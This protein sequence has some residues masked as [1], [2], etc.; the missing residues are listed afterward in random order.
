MCVCVHTQPL[1]LIVHRFLCVHSIILY[2]IFV[3]KTGFFHIV[4][5]CM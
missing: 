4:C 3:A 5:V 1:Q 2:I